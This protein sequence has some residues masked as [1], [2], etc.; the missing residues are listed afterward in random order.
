MQTTANIEKKYKHCQQTREWGKIPI[1]QRRN[2]RIDRNG[3]NVR[4]N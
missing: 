3:A 4:T 2:R 1:P